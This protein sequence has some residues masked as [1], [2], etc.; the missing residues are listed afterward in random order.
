MRPSREAHPS[1]RTRVRAHSP[2]HRLPDQWPNR[3]LGDGRRILLSGCSR[4]YR[5]R[6]ASL[7]PGLGSRV[8]LATSPNIT[9]ILAAVSATR[10][11]WALAPQG[12]TLPMAITMDAREAPMGPVLKGA[13]DAAERARAFRR[14]RRHSLLVKMLRVALPLAAAGVAGFYALTLGVSWQLGAGTS[15]GRGGPAHGRRP[16]DEEPDLL[17]ADQGRRP[18][19]GAG[20]ESH[21]RV[22]QGGADQADRHRRRSAAGQRR[23]HQAQGQ[24]R[25]ARQC[26]ERARALRRHR[27]RCLERHEGAHVARH[28]LLQGAPGR[29]QAAGRPDD[30][31]RQGAGRQP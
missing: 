29:L 24:A 28:G 30:A 21:R 7:G 8:R 15:Q 13:P 14:A 18:L 5:L 11:K 26:Q 23:H 31:D 25:P 4:R 12:G 6:D 22:Q 10:L 3:P 27:D 20:Q 2:C 1:E 19:R 16:D 17:R 9:Q